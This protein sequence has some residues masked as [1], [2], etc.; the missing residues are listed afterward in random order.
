MEINGTL[1]VSAGGDIPLTLKSPE[2]QQQEASP[3]T[4]R[5]SLSGSPGVM[6]SEAPSTSTS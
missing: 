6:V 5:I 1:P 3:R 2:L 4:W